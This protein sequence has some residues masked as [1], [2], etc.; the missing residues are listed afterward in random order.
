MTRHPETNISGGISFPLLD[1]SVGYTSY[2][3]TNWNTDLTG[4]I[5]TAHVSINADTGVSFVANPDGCGGGTPTVR[6]EFQ[7]TTAGGW[8]ETDY[9]WSHA[10]AATLDAATGGVQTLVGNTTNY[11]D[12]SDIYGHFADDPA[13]TAA[14]ENALKDVKEVSLS[15][16]GNCY[17]RGVAVKSGTGNAMFNLV[18]YSIN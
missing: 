12:W 13:Y 5:I 2:M 7:R 16:G 15:F 6:L 10:G 14:F 1:E 11:G 9:W 3:L 4:K 17:A 18:D 8:V